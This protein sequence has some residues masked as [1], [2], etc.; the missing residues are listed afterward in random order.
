ML[1]DLLS[2]EI[3]KN[4]PLYEEC[5]NIVKLINEFDEFYIELIDKREFSR[6]ISLAIVTSNS[7][8]KYEYNHSLFLKI[9]NNSSF[10]FDYICHYIL[11][12]KFRI[13]RDSIQ[14]ISDLMKYMFIINKRNPNGCL[15]FKKI[16]ELIL[17]TYKKKYEE[18]LKKIEEVIDGNDQLQH[19]II[20][21]FIEV[22][23]RL[24]D[25]FKEIILTKIKTPRSNGDYNRYVEEYS[26]ILIQ[27]MELTVVEV[28]SINRL[29]IDNKVYVT[30][31]VINWINDYDFNVIKNIKEV[32][33]DTE[34]KDII[35]A[36]KEIERFRF[37]FKDLVKK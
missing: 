4:C 10:N 9:L 5:S 14:S 27:A 28:A 13:W 24:Y 31:E 26:N 12:V 33:K 2:S 3:C 32:M 18:L 7:I 22:H 8:S 16:I 21:Y 1:K 19:D 15:Q 11:D 17:D 36:E 25:K 34:I 20:D 29:L 6:F 23:S 30:S 35:Y 37:L